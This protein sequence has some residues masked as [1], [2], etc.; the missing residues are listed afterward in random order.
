MIETM[1]SFPISPEGFW[2][3]TSFSQLDLERGPARKPATPFKMFK[4]LISASFNSR[5]SNDHRSEIFE[6]RY[7]VGYSRVDL[8]GVVS[9]NAPVGQAS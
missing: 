9:T 2:T 6:R 1:A 7:R 3:W 4:S 8:V 5:Q